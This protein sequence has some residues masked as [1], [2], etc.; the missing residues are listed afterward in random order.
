MFIYFF[1]FPAVSSTQFLTTYRQLL[2]NKNI[3]LKLHLM[4]DHIQ[5]QLEKNKMGLGFIAEHGGESIHKEFNNLL[6]FFANKKALRDRLDQLHQVMKAHIMK[7][8]PDV[9]KN[10][11]LAKNR[12]EN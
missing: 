4:E 10:V 6:H 5:E 3:F 1:L 11:P 12:K 8:H 2:P 9:R 7:V